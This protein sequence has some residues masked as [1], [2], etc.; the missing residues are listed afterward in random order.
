MNS[1]KQYDLAGRV[2][3]CAM[4]VHRE[5]GAG[6]NESV[7][8]NALIHELELQNIAVLPEQKIIVRYKNAIVG[9]FAADLVVENKLILELKSVQNLITAHEVQL[10][11]YLT[12]THISE[13]L[14]LNFG[15]SSLEYKKKF[16]TYQKGA[17]QNK[18]PRLQE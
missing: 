14:L 9:E 13:G 17:I 8:Q 11:N 10:V 5:L 12:A 18:T 15:T 1:T 2:I 6:F 7:Y 16:L 4:T 3:G